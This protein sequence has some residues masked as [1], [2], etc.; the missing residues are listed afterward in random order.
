MEAIDVFRWVDGIDDDL[1]VQ[2]VRQGQLDENPVDVIVA[3]E[4]EDQREEIGLGR[5][6][7]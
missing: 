6:R 2:M 7:G 1:V 3:V 4:L 5:F